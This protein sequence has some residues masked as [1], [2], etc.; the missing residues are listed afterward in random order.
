M[1]VRDDAR[2]RRRQ[3][4]GGRHDVLVELGVL[5]VV[6]RPVLR[7]LVRV[8]RRD[9]VRPPPH[10]NLLDAVLVDGLLL[11]QALQTPIMSF[12]ELPGLRDRDPHVVRLFQGVV[13]G[14]DG[15]L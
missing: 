9:V 6:A 10:S 4:F 8:G 2:G 13:E 1:P 5:R 11:V 3:T 12:V 7:G 14:A 15:S